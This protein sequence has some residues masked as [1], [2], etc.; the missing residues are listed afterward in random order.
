MG[1]ARGR[2]SGRLPAMSARP[3][4]AGKTA[5][6]PAKSPKPESEPVAPRGD[7]PPVDAALWNLAERLIATQTAS[8]PNAAEAAAPRAT[9]P[10]PAAG[11]PPPALPGTMPSANRMRL[12]RLPNGQTVAVPFKPQ[13]GMPD[14]SGLQAQ[15][16]QPSP[17][18]APAIAIAAE[19]PPPAVRPF[20][21]A[22]PEP[23]PAPAPQA[24]FA[25][26]PFN[27]SPDAPTDRA[28]GRASFSILRSK[29]TADDPAPRPVPLPAPAPERRSAAAA[30]PLRMLAETLPSAAPSA[31]AEDDDDWEEHE[32]QPGLSILGWLGVVVAIGGAA[33]V[34]SV[35][36]G[37]I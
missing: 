10:R 5:A 37:W 20:T 31:A 16:Q 24:E 34:G 15:L 3:K 32:P 6:K 13:T 18:S 25:R 11:T 28:A 17:P 19:P 8:P 33:V 4:A 30:A 26:N 22:P 21:M 27:L 35:F 1:F 9:F 23:V 29:T 12:V 14:L 2:R 7:Q 36:Q